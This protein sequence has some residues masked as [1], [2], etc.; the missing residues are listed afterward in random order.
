MF[1]TAGGAVASFGVAATAVFTVAVAVARKTGM[2][3]N[4]HR[5]VVLNRNLFIRNAF[6]S[7]FF[8]GIHRNDAHDAK[9]RD[10]D[11]QNNQ[12]FFISFSLSTVKIKA[13][14]VAAAYV[15][16]YLLHSLNSVRS[17]SKYFCHSGVASAKSF[18]CNSLATPVSSKT[19]PSR[20]R[21]SEAKAVSRNA[22]V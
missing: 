7:G 20:L 13:A 12:I 18:S 6:S 2:R 1:A 3:T 9:Q 19:T 8:R 15:T 17:F 10:N 4:F 16:F 14:N 21:F 5:S 22:S 11:A